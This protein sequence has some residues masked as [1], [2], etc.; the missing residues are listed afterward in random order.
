MTCVHLVRAASRGFEVTC[1]QGVNLYLLLDI[2]NNCINCI[3]GISLAFELAVV[4]CLF[5]K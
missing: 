4:F 1:L 5:V 2:F 3:M